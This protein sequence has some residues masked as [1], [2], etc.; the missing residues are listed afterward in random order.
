MEP[1]E[2]EMK[3]DSYLK[4]KG[5]SIAELEKQYSGRKFGDLILHH[6]KVQN[7]NQINDAVIGL[8]RKINPVLKETTEKFLETI[9][10]GFAKSKDFWK[11]DCGAALVLYTNSTKAEAKKFNI[12]VNDDYTFDVFNLIVLSLAQKASIDS[13]FKKFIKKS[14]K[15][16]GIF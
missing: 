8:K 15:R 7:L 11:T 4:S 13:E 2:T 6:L 5:L 9:I 14:V 12:E 1:K 16:F 3:Q 10:Y